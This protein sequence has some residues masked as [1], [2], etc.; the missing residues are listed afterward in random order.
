[1]QPFTV[2]PWLCSRSQIPSQIQ[3]YPSRTCVLCEAH[4]CVKPSQGNNAMRYL[5]YVC[6]GKDKTR[7]AQITT[8]G[9]CTTEDRYVYQGGD[10]DDEYTE[11]ECGVGWC[12]YLEVAFGRLFFRR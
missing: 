2:S 7:I 1:M 10:D 11:R 6:G 8:K 3:S 4:L 9:D 5:R 12:W